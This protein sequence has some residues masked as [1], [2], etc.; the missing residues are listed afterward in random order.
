M[1]INESVLDT[2]RAELAKHISG[3]RLEHSLAVEAEATALGIL[4]EMSENEIFKLRAAAILHDITKAL[5][6]VTQIDLCQKRGI[7]LSLDD[8]KSPKVLH[9]ISGATIAKELFS[10]Y[11][12]DDIYRAILNHTT[13]AEKMSLYEKLIYLADYIEPTRTF[14]DCVHLRGYFYE[15]D[16]LPTEKHLNKT[17]LL[18]F[19]KT[20]RVLLEE[21]QFIHPRTIQARNGILNELSRLDKSYN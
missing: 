12:D 18:S 1:K 5:D 8:L 2:M 17:L 15:S 19:D 4:F 21:K 7:E 6:T 13:G 16:A 10:E 20:L 3:H 14:A 9:S 11:V